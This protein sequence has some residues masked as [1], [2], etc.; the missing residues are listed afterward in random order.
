MAKNNL[1][2]SPKTTK[3][4]TGIPVYKRDSMSKSQMDSAAAYKKYKIEKLKPSTPSKTYIKDVPKSTL[5]VKS[6]K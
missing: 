3:P 1:P 5:K 6:K 2:K 4:G